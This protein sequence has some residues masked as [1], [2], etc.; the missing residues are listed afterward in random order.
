MKTNFLKKNKK[1]VS[2][3]VIMMILVALVMGI[4]VAVWQVTKGTVEEKLSQAEACNTKNIGKIVLDPDYCCYN[5]EKGYVVFSIE[6]KDIEVEEI[7]ISIIGE[8]Y[9]GNIILNEEGNELTNIN[10]LYLYNTITG[11]KT[12]E[13][14]ILETGKKSYLAEINFVATQIKVVPTIN[15][16]NCDTLV[17]NI[18]N[19][20]DCSLYNIAEPI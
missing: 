9:S 17:S 2:G 14:K 11:E 1:A 12:A 19:L 18:N 8:E 15:G 20:E 16:E 13:P 10:K 5:S 4:M 7:L 6:R 3:V